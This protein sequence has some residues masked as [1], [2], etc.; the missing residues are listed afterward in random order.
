MTG[1][2]T[3]LNDIRDLSLSVAIRRSTW[4]VMALEGVHLLGLALL[5]GG[6]TLIALAAVRRDGLHGLSVEKLSGGLSRVMGAGFLLMAASGV[7]IAISMPYKYYLNDAFRLKMVLLVA[8]IAASA[9]LVWS[10]RAPS[11]VQRTLALVAFVL[12]LGAGVCGRA[13]G[14]L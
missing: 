4:A 3:L 14:F 11:S 10:P 8:A 13:I 1:D 5:G 2:F 12:W 6:V 7:F 9:G